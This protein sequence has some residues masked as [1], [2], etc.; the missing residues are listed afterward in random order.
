[1][2]TRPRMLVLVTT[3]LVGATSIS[4][5]A[6]ADSNDGGAPVVDGP[7]ATTADAPE[8]TDT[9]SGE[10]DASPDVHAYLDAGPVEAGPCTN[11]GWCQTPLP[12][13]PIAE[14][15]H[16]LRG[17][18]SDGAGV[19]WAVSEEG[20]ILRWDGTT[21]AIQFSTTTGSLSTIW[22]RGPTDLWVG[23]E[24]GFWHGEGPTSASITWTLEDLGEPQVQIASIWGSAAGDLW[25]VG[26]STA[27]YKARAYF[28]GAADTTWTADPLS[29]RTDV[30]DLTNV[31]GTNDGEV[32]A[33]G[34]IGFGTLILHRRALGQPEPIW[35]DEDPYP[36]KRSSDPAA[37]YSG[38]GSIGG[39]IWAF[40]KVN[41]ANA[42]YWTGVTDPMNGTVAWKRNNWIGMLNSKTDAFSRYAVWGPAPDDVFTIA[43][44]ARI[45]HWDGTAWS[46]VHITP[47]STPVTA[48]L[49]AMMGRSKDD[50]W[51]VGDNIAIHKVSPR[52]VKGAK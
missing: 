18:W 6:C 43:D 27:V 38:L 32:W 39:T 3:A 21:W 36:D 7:D 24:G 35:V 15:S 12:A 50:I 48:N 10:E 11:E 25:A 1:M 17:V 29:G 45:N 9:D 26:K 20:K 30:A 16:T 49:Y 4:F 31:W 5:L 51:V 44:R 40:G 33:I 34:K 42:M 19:A 41:Y 23:G 22:G 52:D 46:T 47:T 2:R 13:D 14:L 37:S 8:R 28:R